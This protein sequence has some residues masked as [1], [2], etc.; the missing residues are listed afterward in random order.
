MVSHSHVLQWVLETETGLTCIVECFAAKLQIILQ[1]PATDFRADA[2]LIELGVD[3]L[4]AVEI[5]SW[6]L[7]ETSVDV[8]VLKILG[9][10]STVELCKHAVDQMPRHLLRSV[11]T[12]DKPSPDLANGIS[13]TNGS[14]GQANDSTT[15]ADGVHTNGAVAPAN[16]RTPIKPVFMVGAVEVDTAASN[17]L[18]VNPTSTHMNG[19]PHAG[20][21]GEANRRPTDTIGHDTARELAQLPVEKVLNDGGLNGAMVR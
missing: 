21:N 5:R 17:G 3:S 2:A 11:G 7:K 18:T 14:M 13:R 1:I 6:F 12:A 4:V 10:A 8:A 9:G 19:L 20:V 15:V 16:G